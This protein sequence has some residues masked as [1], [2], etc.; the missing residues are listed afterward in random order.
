[1][2]AD[3]MTLGTRQ[4]SRRPVLVWLAA[5]WIVL[6]LLAAIFAGLLPLTSPATAVGKARTPPFKF[7]D[8][9]RILGTDASGRSNLAR[10]V[11]GARNS[12]LIGV[13][14]ATIGLVIGGFVGLVSGYLRGWV[15]R[16]SSF[17]VD[18]ML[19]FPPLILLIAVSSALGAKVSTVL[20]A[21][22]VLVIPTFIRLQRAAAM[23]WAQRPFVLA[24]RSYGSGETSIAIRH[25]LPN[26]ML[27]MLSFIPVVISN[28]IVAEGALSFLGLGI[29]SPTPS[30]GV[31]IADGRRALRTEPSVVFVPAVFVFLTVMSFNV[32]GEF[33]RSRFESR[34]RT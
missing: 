6:L 21:L 31:M 9:G 10:A 13:L 5:V 15:D 26:S 7:F 11:Y 18:T 28:L 27:T 8:A 20:V 33:A 12:M 1:M 29:P 19:A 25:V 22:S 14:A 3:P 24:A 16:V 30:W 17:Y 23:S 34:N 4:R 2:S 32:V